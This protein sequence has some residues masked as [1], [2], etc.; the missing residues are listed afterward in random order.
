MKCVSSTSFSIAINGNIHGFFKGKRGLRQGNP[1]SPYLFTLVMEVL[2]LMLQRKA[3]Q[4]EGF[5]FHPGCENLKLI[6][7]CFADD[8]FLCAHADI[9]SVKVIF[10]A[11]DEFKRCSG[12]TPSIPKSTVFIIPDNVIKDI[13]KMLRG[14]LWC[15][16]EMKR[17]KAKVKWDNVCR[18]KYEG[19]LGYRT[20]EKVSDIFQNGAWSW[21]QDWENRVPEL[22]NAVEWAHVIWFSQ[23]IPRHAFM[24]W[25]LMGERLKTQDKLKTWEV[26]HNNILVCS[27]CK[28]VEDTHAHLFFS[29]PYAA[30]ICRKGAHM[31]NMPNWGMDWKL[32]CNSLIPSAGRNKAKIVVAKIMF[33]AMVYYIWQERNA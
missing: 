25:L 18:P 4:I 5:T 28:Q 13:E 29:C 24:V 21:L 23:C 20:S 22:C 30:S 7:L 15:Q 2:S 16:S 6:N 3:W 27:L 12:L 17:G 11:L 32:I 19:G 33:A 9:V 10:E 1:L 26:N 31:V 14:F 8:L